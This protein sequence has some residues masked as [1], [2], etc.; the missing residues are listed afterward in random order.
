M[1]HVFDMRYGLHGVIF[2]LDAT[3]IDFV[4]DGLTC[5]VLEGFWLILSTKITAVSIE[6]LFIASQQVW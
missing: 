4:A 1:F 5:F 6:L 3:A 2:D